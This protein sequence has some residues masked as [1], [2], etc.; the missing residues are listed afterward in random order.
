MFRD[1]HSQRV[2][3]YP[4]ASSEHVRDQLR[5]E[6]EVGP[7]NLTIVEH[8][9]PWDANAGS[10]WTSF[11]IARLRYTRADKGWTFYWRDRNRRLHSYDRCTPSPRVDDLLAVQDAGKRSRWT[12]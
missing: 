7:R 12:M 8:R 9:P 5:W 4:Q 3:A 11:P 10:E 6:C 1:K 2:H